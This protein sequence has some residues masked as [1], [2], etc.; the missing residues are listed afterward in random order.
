MEKF[1]F[2]PEEVKKQI[3]EELIANDVLIVIIQGEV[4]APL[5]KVDWDNFKGSQENKEEFMRDFKNI[6]EKD[7]VKYL[8]LLLKYRKYLF[9]SL[10]TVF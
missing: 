3:I 2:N 6:S 1:I 8:V 9:F 4:E 10:N 5:Y 7:L